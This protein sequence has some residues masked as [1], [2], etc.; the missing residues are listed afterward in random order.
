MTKN[1]GHNFLT[2]IG[3]LYSHV[4][5]RVIVEKTGKFPKD[6]FE[7]VAG[8]KAP[9]KKKAPFVGKKSG[10][11]AADGFK[12]PKKS[13][14]KFSVSSEKTENENINT[15]M[16]KNFD[17]LVS[18]A[19]AGRLQLEDNDIETI[20]DVAA[21]PESGSPDDLSL[22]DDAGGEPGLDPELEDL[23]PAE[24]VEQDRKSTRLNSSHVSES[25][26]PSSA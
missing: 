5:D 22:G 23:S 17:K 7:Q 2:E 26:M 3:Q 6:T 20:D 24:I 15:N 14:A 21:A 19:M 1:K 16:S 8:K 4:L 25:R 18:D 10:P 9:K 13:D 12:A 11:Q